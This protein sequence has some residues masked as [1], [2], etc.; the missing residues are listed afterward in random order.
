MPYN[1]K[2]KES[3]GNQSSNV[4]YIPPLDDNGSIIDKWISTDER[5]KIHKMAPATS[6]NIL[7]A[8]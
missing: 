7:A 5:N 8:R 1:N 4:I 6:N 3:T 2:K